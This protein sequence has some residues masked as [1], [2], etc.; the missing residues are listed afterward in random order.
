MD[1]YKEDS[2]A[3]ET[4]ENEAIVPED[5]EALWDEDESFG[6]AEG[7]EAE[8]DAQPETAGAED[9]AEA[10][11]EQD[12]TE[13]PEQKDGAEDQRVVLKHNGEE[14]EADREKLIELAQKGLDY[15]RIKAERDSFKADGPTMQRY[16]EQESFLRE[17]AASGDMDVQT[18]MDTT[19]ARMLMAK[20]P[21]IGEEEALRR[22]R[23]DAK[24][25]AEKKEAAKAEPTPEERRQAMFADF[26]S[27]YPNVEAKDIPKEVWEDAARNWDLTGA[28]RSWE[29]K[30]L[31]A[32]N[33]RLRQN[34]RNKERSTGSR[35]STASNDRTSFDKLWYDEDD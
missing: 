20:E 22:V 34:Q 5:F 19:R 25:A 23:E 1:E 3:Q 17:L 7:K 8:T 11:P 18:L 14:V 35:K 24:K 31:K 13:E 15:D 21:G 26:L 6:D 28:Y 29:N 16:K 10:E 30:Q 12:K 2:A 9:E 32:E 4:E 33:E 27:A